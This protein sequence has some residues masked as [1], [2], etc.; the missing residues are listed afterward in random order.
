MADKL[1]GLDYGTRRIGVAVSFATLAEPLEVIANPTT[2]NES[3]VTAAALQRISELCQEHQIQALVVGMSENHM[4][5]L[6][7][8]FVQL[9]EQHLHLPIHLHDET[10]TSATVQARLRE[11]GVNLSRQTTAIDHYAAALIL[12]D[13]LAS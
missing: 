2:T 1:L 8:Q 11:Q 3:V 13:F 4:A 9:L 12:E 6:T 5:K 10:L 7:Q